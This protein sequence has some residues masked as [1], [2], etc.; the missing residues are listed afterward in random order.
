MFFKRN[1]FFISLTQAAFLLVLF[2]HT[3]GYAKAVEIKT[4]RHVNF[5]VLQ[6]KHEVAFDPIISGSLG[7]II[8]TLEHQ[9]DVLFS[10]HTPNIKDRDIINIQTDVLRLTQA[11]VLADSGFNCRFIFDDESDEQ[12]SFYSIS[13]VC[14]YLKATLSGT[15]KVQTLIKRTMLPDPSASFDVWSKVYE[16][17]QT[18]VIFYVDID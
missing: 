17:T 3:T 1:Y 16:N 15:S 12:M 2:L 11:N 18:G 9:A 4:E 10:S 13:G 14:D 7:N 8:V 5:L 6:T